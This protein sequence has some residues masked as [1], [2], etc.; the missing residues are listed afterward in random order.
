LGRTAR[1]WFA[2]IAV[3]LALA[4][5]VVPAAAKVD[6]ET[7]GRHP[8]GAQATATRGLADGE[9]G[10]LAGLSVFADDAHRYELDMFASA[11]L[12]RYFGEGM[13]GGKLIRLARKR[14]I[15]CERE[16]ARLRARDP[17]CVGQ[18]GGA[19]PREPKTIGQVPGGGG[20]AAPGS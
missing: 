9:F 14:K 15:D 19:R 6:A 18:V 20:A 16:G 4:G 1:R 8:T 2:P 12:Q 3:A 13:E 10:I 17:E 11:G 7:F 5:T